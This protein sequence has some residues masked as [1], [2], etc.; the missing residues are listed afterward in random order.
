MFDLPISR[1]S[2]VFSPLPSSCRVK[3]KTQ[4]TAVTHFS[5]SSLLT[6]QNYLHIASGGEEPLQ[7]KKRRSI[8]QI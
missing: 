7:L 8:S 1:H 5:N 3:T 2:C 4:N 6:I